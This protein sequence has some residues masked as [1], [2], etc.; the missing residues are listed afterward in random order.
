MHTG[1]SLRASSSMIYPY[2][3]S[4]IRLLDHLNIN[5][6]KGR[7]DM[8]KAFYFDTLGLIP[9]PR[10]KENL[11]LGRKTLWANAGITQFHFS[12]GAPDAQVFDGIITLS[13][14]SRESLEK[15]RSKLL[16]APH[17]LKNSKCFKWEVIDDDEL[18]VSDPWGSV[19]RLV[20]D[21]NAVDNR[22]EQPGGMSLASCISDLCVFVPE[23]ANLD[24]I[25]RFYHKILGATSLPP[26]DS[27]ERK[28]I[29][30]P[31]QTLT[32]RRIASPRKVDHADVRMETD[33]IA[34]Y[35]AHISMYV[36]NFAKCYLEA[37][38]INAT[39]VNHR[40]K[41]R[42][43]NLDEA[44]DQCMFRCFNIIDPED[45]NSGP[46]LRLEHEIRSIVTN[47]G[48]KYKSCPFYD[49]EK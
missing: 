10:K 18:I 24:G 40:F 29:T 45:L 23:N 8:I 38:T 36:N 30:S 37:E 44:S 17:V 41:R 13:Y 9:D 26:A 14:P 12:E 49:I 35:G 25:V 33:G 1:L 31:F 2:P 43:Y 7:H 47:D 6:E 27:N 5:H 20:V 15:V 34:N 46:I 39:F 42:A 22:G 28:I 11:D 48:R 3:D 4:N 21:P 32:F 16:C 19:F